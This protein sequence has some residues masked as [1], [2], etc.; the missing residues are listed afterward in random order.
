M[1]DIHALAATLAMAYDTEKGGESE[2]RTAW[3]PNTKGS[4]NCFVDYQ[5][6]DGK[7]SIDVWTW[8]QELFTISREGDELPEIRVHRDIPNEIIP[9]LKTAY[10]LSRNLYDL[11]SDMETATK[12]VTEQEAEINRL[13]AV[14]ATMSAERGI[15]RDS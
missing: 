13:K 1:S 3:V 9:A 7:E 12:R 14:I 15:I 10:A 2:G 4:G 8:K 5:S 6:Q 11:H